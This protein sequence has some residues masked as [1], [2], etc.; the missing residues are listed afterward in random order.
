MPTS[1]RGKGKCEKLFLSFFF[2]EL[3]GQVKLLR[4]W[5]RTLTVCSSRSIVCM[6]LKIC[7]FD[8]CAESFPNS[9]QKL[10]SELCSK[11]YEGL[12][13]VKSEAIH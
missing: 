11:S 4:V 2:R 13:I 6:E 12:K 5:S 8:L 3:C 10:D 9:F 7:E 1:T